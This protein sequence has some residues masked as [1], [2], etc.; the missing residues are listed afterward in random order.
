MLPNVSRAGTVRSAD[1][2]IRNDSIGLNDAREFR[3]PCVYREH[4]RG[5]FDLSGPNRD[6]RGR[7]DRHA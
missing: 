7:F 4:A 5:D 6:F 1:D 2:A 3:H